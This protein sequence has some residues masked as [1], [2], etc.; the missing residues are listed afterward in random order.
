MR[1]FLR[2]CVPSFLFLSSSTWNLSEF[3]SRVKWDFSSEGKRKRS[4]K[5]FILKKWKRWR[6]WIQNHIPMGFLVHFPPKVFSSCVRAALLRTPNLSHSEGPKPRRI[7]YLT[8]RKHHNLP[9]MQ[10]QNEGQKSRSTIPR[11]L[12][13]EN[14][15]IRNMLVFYLIKATLYVSSGNLPER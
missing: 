9:L 13:L 6:S 14:L 3:T 5:K 15:E 2:K 11:N 7:A 4:K 12:V 10:R 1:N 8:C